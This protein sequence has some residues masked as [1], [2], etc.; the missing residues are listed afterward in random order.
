[1][2]TK[3]IK[4]LSRIHP[5]HRFIIKYFLSLL[6]RP[7]NRLLMGNPSISGTLNSFLGG[8]ISFYFDPDKIKSNTK[9]PQGYPIPPKHYMV[10]L[11]SPEWYVQSGKEDFDKIIETLNNAAIR[12]NLNWNIL[13][14]GCSNGRIIRWFSEW[15]KAGE[16]WG[17]DISTEQIMWAKTNL[18]P[19][20]KFIT[21]T[22]A[23]HLPFEDCYFNFIYAGSVFTHI[24][25]LSDAWLMELRRILKPD[26][27]LYLTIHDES[28]IKFHKSRADRDGFS[29]MIIDNKMFKQF[30]ISGK[31]FFSIGR[32][33]YS[34]VFY[35]LE[36]FINNVKTYF[37]VVSINP[38]AYRESQTGILLS[39]FSTV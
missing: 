33:T 31:G 12:P 23:P 6:G 3:H 24:D 34:Q 25:D 8:K 16:V 13:D 20:F 5:K 14:F 10:G 38:L 15:T 27:F 22:T 30:N 7:L 37:D 39:K 11:P 36:F 35:Q 18:T 32:S 28:T 1:M 29:K 4:I 19:P 17:V 2:N 9:D 26:G 21:S